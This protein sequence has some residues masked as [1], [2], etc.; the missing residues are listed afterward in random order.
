[1]PF[2]MT[3]VLQL[4]TSVELQSSVLTWIKQGNHLPAN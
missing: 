1:V 3:V 4:S 2:L